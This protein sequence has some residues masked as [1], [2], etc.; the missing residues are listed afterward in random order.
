MHEGKGGLTSTLTYPVGLQV[1]KLKFWS[2][3]SMRETKAVASLRIFRWLVARK[4]EKYQIS[5]PTQTSKF[6]ADN[7]KCRFRN[8]RDE[9]SKFRDVNLF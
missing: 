7:S 4:C 2:A 9:K 5:W 8:S 1:Y 3:L 6:C